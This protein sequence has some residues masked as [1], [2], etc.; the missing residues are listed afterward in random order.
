[1]PPWNVNEIYT[2]SSGT[3]EI[4]D[5]TRERERTPRLYWNASGSGR[6]CPETLDLVGTVHIFTDVLY[7]VTHSV[8]SSIVTA[9]IY[10]MVHWSIKRTGSD[11]A[12]LQ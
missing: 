3:E 8:F 12:R 4:Y 1:V 2:K 6:Q 7:T 11:R 9:P 5:S 10:M